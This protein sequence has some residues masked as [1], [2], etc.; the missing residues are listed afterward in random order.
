MPA[1]GMDVRGNRPI[2][3]AFAWEIMSM[4]AGASIAEMKREELVFVLGEAL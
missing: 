4:L 2:P 1:N 3:H